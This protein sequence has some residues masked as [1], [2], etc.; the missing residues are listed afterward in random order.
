MEKVTG[1][2]IIRIDGRSIR[3]KA[4]A[5]LSLGGVERTPVYADGQLIGFSEKPV[6]SQLT[7]TLAHTSQTDLAALNET[8]DAAGRFETDTGVVFNIQ[9]LTLTKPAEITGGEGDAT[10]EFMGKPA[11]QQ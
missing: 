10:V 7:A 1:T 8:N 5:K 2:C 11:V 4:G 9:G 3:S 6:A